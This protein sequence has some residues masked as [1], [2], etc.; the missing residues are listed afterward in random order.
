MRTLT[1]TLVAVGLAALLGLPQAAGAAAPT[2]D[3]IAGGIPSGLQGT[4]VSLTASA[5]D[6]GPDGNLYFA[7]P[8]QGIVWRLDGDGTVHHVAG[9][10]RLCLPDPS[11]CGGDDGPAADVYLSALAGLAVADDGDI[12]LS[13]Q[14]ANRIR[15]ID[16]QT[17]IITTVAGNG[18]M[19]YVADAEDGPATEFPVGLPSQIALDSTGGLYITSMWARRI[20]Y[21]DTDG[22]IRTVAGCGNQQFPSCFY[23]PRDGSPIEGTPI[24]PNAG[25]N[26]N[27]FAIA[28]SPDDELYFADAAEI[29]KADFETGVYR[30]IAGDSFQYADFIGEGEGGPAIDARL[31]VI[32][33]MAFGPDGSLYL[34]EGGGTFDQPWNRIQK[35]DAPAAPTSTLRHAGGLGTGNGF[36]GDG[37]DAKKARFAFS[38][39]YETW[40]GASLT[41][42]PDGDVYIADANNKRVRAIDAA[43]GFVNTVA[44]NGYGGAGWIYGLN[45]LQPFSNISQGLWKRGGFSGDG[46]E[47]TTAQLFAPADV[48]ADRF[49]NVYVLDRESN[50]VRKITPDGKIAT[51]AGSG[52]VGQR[53][54]TEQTN[55]ALGDGADATKAQLRGPTAIALDR[56]GTQLYIADRSTRRVRQVNMGSAA[57][58]AYPL[59]T[60]PVRIEAGHIQTIAGPGRSVATQGAPFGP[61]YT[62][63]ALVKPYCGEGLP[64]NEYAPND[65]E[66]LATDTNGNL[67]FSDAYVNQVLRVEAATGLVVAV[68]GVPHASDC[69]GDT[70][71]AVPARAA[72]LCGPAGLTV[73]GTSLYIAETGSP[74]F[75]D[76]LPNGYQLASR[77]RKVNLADPAGQTT[78]VAGTGTNGFGGDGAAARQ[79]QLTFAHDVAVGPDGSVYISDTGNSRIR[80]VAT[81]GKISTVA[82]NGVWDNYDYTGCDFSGDGGAAVDAQLCGPMGISFGQNGTLY[83]ADGINNRIR[84][85]R[86]L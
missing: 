71:D 52:C 26:G 32:V 38:Q 49:G 47:A 69:V 24:A 37:A 10:G 31:G 50:R 62:S 66:G 20:H 60:T 65:I 79:A 80:R 53:C 23:F 72:R 63:C 82:G 17:G 14:R 48:E 85:I 6:F 45:D 67:Y 86:G 70:D 11:R 78:I 57:F 29:V 33:G 51:V 56:T 76:S 2:I 34:M 1:R 5:L 43:T 46:R 41:V 15:K 77:V 40:A 4:Q 28:V 58:T 36:G 12:Y 68:A 9:G 35:I 21:L 84:V 61:Q 74:G 3:T 22:T 54:A 83:V 42:G 13:E 64:W 59:G 73:A 39:P 25:G 81:D 16:A 44:G 19:D 75:A 8:G 55:A 27:G 18:D 7:D 30:V